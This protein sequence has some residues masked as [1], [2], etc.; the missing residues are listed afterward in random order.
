MIVKSS[1]ERGYNPNSAANIKR[2]MENLNKCVAYC[3]DE[4][5]MKAGVYRIN[6]F[7]L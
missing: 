7:T 6:V 4:V 1:E 2:S 3:V 5:S